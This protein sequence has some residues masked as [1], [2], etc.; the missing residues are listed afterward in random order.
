MRLVAWIQSPGIPIR[1]KYC[2]LAAI[3]PN[4]DV[5]GI[6]EIGTFDV[7]EP[8]PVVREAVAKAILAGHALL[9]IP[10]IPLR[11][12]E[13]LWPR[14]WPWAC[15][16]YTFHEQLQWIEGRLPDSQILV[17]VLSL[18]HSLDDLE[19]AQK[20]VS[21]PETRGLYAMLIKAWA[22]VL[23]RND[24]SPPEYGNACIYIVGLLQEC[25]ERTTNYGYAE[26]IEGAGGSVDDLA[27]LFV[28][29]LGRILSYPE[30][31]TTRT[32]VYSADAIFGLVGALEEEANPAAQAGCMLLTPLSSALL[33]RGIISVTAEFICCL[34]HNLKLPPVETLDRC[35][36]FLGRLLSSVAGYRHLP[37]ALET[38]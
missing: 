13:V 22:S 28:R 23:T 34:C 14:Y 11:A 20:I 25:W 5:A 29:H 24:V 4:L 8:A 27:S 17:N 16:L 3:Y 30:L 36:F 1:H 15:F 2:V 33:D 26:M 31:H 6:P 12:F 10:E 38:P 35:L 18:L 7:P 21:R 9:N 19:G 32:L 37:D